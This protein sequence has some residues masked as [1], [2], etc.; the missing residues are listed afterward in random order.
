[1]KRDVIGV[2]PARGGS[3][4]IVGK[5]IVSLAGKPLL[6]WTIDAARA[7]ACISRV[8][9]STDD[10]AIADVARTA[11][12]DVPF[13]RPAAL[14]ADDTPGIDPIIHTLETLGVRDGW[15]CVLQPTS[16]LRTAA[17]ID[18]AR[19]LAE[20]RGADAV[21]GVT[22]VRQHRAWQK[23]IDDDGWVVSAES[24]PATRQA[25]PPMWCPNGALYLVRVDVVLQQRTLLPRR[26]AHW[27]MPASRS[28]D[29]DIPDDLVLAAALL[30]GA[31]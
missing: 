7:A 14:A 1:M 27:P 26:T 23:Q 28:I 11:G 3:K 13:M 31:L 18:G 21:L 17:D 22:A 12:A 19:A 30:R 20:E 6:Q 25:L 29:I 9:V 8:V 15:V 16:P 10:D 24:I 4:G 2:V 5:N